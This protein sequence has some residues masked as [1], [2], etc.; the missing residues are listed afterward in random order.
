M[1]LGPYVR[2]R[3]RTTFATCAVTEVLSAD[4][5]GGS[6]DARV[7]GS[8]VASPCAGAKSHDDGASTSISQLPETLRCPLWAE[9][10][11]APVSRLEVCRHSSCLV[12][13][14]SDLRLGRQR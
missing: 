7:S 2:W 6:S 8:T 5:R 11:R 1:Q 13:N 14:V 4:T 12:F 3:C 9:G 10:L